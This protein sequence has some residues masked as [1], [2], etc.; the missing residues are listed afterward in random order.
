MK[1]VSGLD[2]Y[3]KLIIVLVL[4]VIQVEASP[5]LWLTCGSEVLDL[6]CT[7]KDLDSEML[8]RVLVN[9]SEMDYTG[10]DIHNYDYVLIVC[11]I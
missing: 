6:L 9:M 3:Y 4:I 10:V 11:G 2:Q 5:T 7:L 1:S 8:C